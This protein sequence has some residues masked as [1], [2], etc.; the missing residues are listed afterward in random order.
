M[1]G[2]RTTTVRSGRL[3]RQA[4]LSVA[5]I[6]GALTLACGK[7]PDVN[8]P[9][10]ESTTPPLPHKQFVEQANVICRATTKA[11]VERIE[12]VGGNN[13]GAGSGDRQ[14]LLDTVE[15]ITSQTLA[16]LRNLTPPPEDA[17]TAGSALD[18]MQAAA[19]A[20]R[21]DPTAPLD[22]IGLNRPEL[23]DFGLT[24]CFTKR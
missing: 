19:D 18:A 11:I 21:R 13:L 24:G 22:P 4:S 7:P 17:A 8:L 9:G 1:R 20:A 3:G 10:P 6:V 12:D 15:P 16:K 14:K 5:V 23:Y 2:R